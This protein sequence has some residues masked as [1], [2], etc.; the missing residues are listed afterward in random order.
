MSER[1]ERGRYGGNGH[2]TSQL[3]KYV[4]RDSLSL[5]CC[6]LPPFSPNRRGRKGRKA[7][8]HS[9]R[10]RAEGAQDGCLLAHKLVAA[11]PSI[12]PCDREKKIAIRRSKNQ[13]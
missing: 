11:C 10:P 1:G 8:L 13:N 3:R 12:L 9:N 2:G 4:V 6:L 5:S 7:D